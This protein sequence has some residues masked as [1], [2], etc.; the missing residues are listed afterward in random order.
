MASPE[1]RRQDRKETVDMKHLKATTKDRKWSIPSKADLGQADH[2]GADGGILGNIRW[3][4]I[5]N[6]WMSPGKGFGMGH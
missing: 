6:S 4:G 5:L 3:L 2:M 1:K